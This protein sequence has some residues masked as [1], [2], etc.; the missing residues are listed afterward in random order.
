MN[1]NWDLFEN[2]DVDDAIDEEERAHGDMLA[3]PATCESILS[4]PARQELMM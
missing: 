3:V 1:W 4:P 2:Q